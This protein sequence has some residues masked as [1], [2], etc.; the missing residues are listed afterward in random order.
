MDS[1]TF[2]PKKI[3]SLKTLED[4]E[5]YPKEDKEKLL[6]TKE[7]V[8]LKD[9]TTE[10]KIVTD[11]NEPQEVGV[12][13]LIVPEDELSN[14]EKVELLA[15]IPGAEEPVLVKEFSPAE[16]KDVK[17]NLLEGRNPIKSKEIILRITKKAKKP[18]NLKVNI[19]I[20]VH[21]TT[22]NINIVYSNNSNNNIAKML[23]SAVTSTPTTTPAP[24]GNCKYLC[25]YII[26]TMLRVGLC[27]HLF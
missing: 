24:S 17:D 19:K 9:G 23:F 27:L 22:G 26:T 1:E 13:R 6:P 25:N 4:N 12:V 5:E 14:I 18:V 21:T 3:V 20:C 16:L 10:L 11:E 15:N 7:G 2:N 8:P